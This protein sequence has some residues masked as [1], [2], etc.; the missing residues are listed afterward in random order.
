MASTV[1]T[2]GLAAIV[3]ALLVMLT[4]CGSD[5]AYSEPVT[6]PA[7]SATPEPAGSPSR[8]G[9][10]RPLGNGLS[11]T[12]SAPKSFVPTGSGNSK[13]PRAV[14]FDVL[15]EN[16]GTT[17]YRPS[18]LVLTASSDG[19]ALRPVIDATQGYAG[20]VGDTDIVPGGR[21]RFSVAFAVRPE[22]TQLQVSAQPDP[23]TPAM[24]MV[25]DGVA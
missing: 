8:A 19:V 22:P 17:A 11:I 20:V 7:T 10:R 24:V 14:G 15:V 23:G 9:E 2:V 6:A 13:T 25:F 18:Q 5:P 16:S 3:C 1:K 12:V 4:G 21:A